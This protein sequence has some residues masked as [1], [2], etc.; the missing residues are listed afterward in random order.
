MSWLGKVLALVGGESTALPEDPEIKS[1]VAAYLAGAG[2]DGYTIEVRTTAEG[3]TLLD[4]PADSLWSVLQSA[5]RSDVIDKR[6]P[7]HQETWRIAAR[8]EKLV[9]EI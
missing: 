6:D 9:S 5:L 8:R 7:R 1:L 3:A 2:A 4:M